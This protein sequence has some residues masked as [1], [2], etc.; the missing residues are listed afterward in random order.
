MPEAQG[1]HKEW[2]HFPGY[3]LFVSLFSGIHQICIPAF[4]FDLPTQ[5]GT[6]VIVEVL[7]KKVHI[8]ITCTCISV[9]ERFAYAKEFYLLLHTCIYDYCITD[10]ITCAYP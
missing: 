2:H 8:N 4:P 1:L 9:F 10:I 5:S 6:Y 3:K 7:V